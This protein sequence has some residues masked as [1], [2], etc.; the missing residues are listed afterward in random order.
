MTK[1]RATWSGQGS[2]VI[3]PIGGVIMTHTDTTFDVLDDR[4]KQ[5]EDLKAVNSNITRFYNYK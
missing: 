4:I 2:K 3:C 5:R 1:F